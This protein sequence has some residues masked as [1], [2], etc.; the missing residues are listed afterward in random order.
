MNIDI[1]EIVIIAVLITLI[2]VLLT[3]TIVLKIKNTKLIS[4]VAQLFV[5]KNVMSEELDRLSFVVNNGPSIENDFIKFL[6][7]SRDSAYEYIEKV[8][9]AIEAL[10][11]AMESDKSSEIDKSYKE[12]IKFLP[13]K[14]MDT[15]E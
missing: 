2:A 11:K 1:I 9:A 5:D 4:V 8:Q 12:L 6:S 7:D 14:N 15:V 13:S 10:Y 3:S